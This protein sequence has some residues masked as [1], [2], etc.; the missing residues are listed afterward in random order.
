MIRFKALGLF[1]ITILIFNFAMAKP[2]KSNDLCDH[3]VTY[4]VDIW[5]QHQRLATEI[6]N[7]GIWPPEAMQGRLDLLNQLNKYLMDT[8]RLIEKHQ[9]VLS[10]EAFE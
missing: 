6:Q 9:C 3:L 10:D 8:A 7:G 1:I 4:Y 2:S 5:H